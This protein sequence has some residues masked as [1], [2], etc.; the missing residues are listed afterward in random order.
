MVPINS[1]MNSYELKLFQLRAQRISDEDGIRQS[2]F[3]LGPWSLQII[4][5]AALNWDHGP[6]SK[7]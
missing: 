6:S 2:G 4:Q 7:H 3:P 1:V 5:I